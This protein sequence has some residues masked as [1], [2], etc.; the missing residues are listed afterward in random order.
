MKTIA[1]ISCILLAG[2][3]DQRKLGILTPE[4]VAVNVAL[5]KK[6]GLHVAYQ[7]SFY[8]G[9]DMIWCVP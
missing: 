8:G 1:I 4:Q 9:I 3:G 7:N 6:L 5:C 2:C